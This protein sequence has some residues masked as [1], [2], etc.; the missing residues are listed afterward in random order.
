[1]NLTRDTYEYILNFASDST[2]LNMLSVN[3]KF[4]DENLFKHIMI[5]RYPELVKYRKENE[6]F[7]NLYIRMIYFIAKL[8]EDFNISFE[9]KF[10][11]PEIFY[12]LYRRERLQFV[13]DA[14]NWYRNTASIE[15][16]DTPFD[17]EDPKHYPLIKIRKSIVDLGGR[18]I[19]PEVLPA[20]ARIVWSIFKEMQNVFKK[21][22]YNVK[23]YEELANKL[24]SFDIKY[25]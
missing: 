25:I 4:R 11:D 3:K 9:M 5:H 7:A 20:R 19:H 24:K 2:I 18:V 22:G 21:L 8:K 12:K 1:M 13:I 16:K 6:T 15:G 14:Y 17:L 23:S 10:E